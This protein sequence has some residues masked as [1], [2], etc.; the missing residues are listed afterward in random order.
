MEKTMKPPR[1][2]DCTDNIKYIDHFLQLVIK[3]TTQYLC[4]VLGYE[5][6]VGMSYSDILREWEPKNL[7]AR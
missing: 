3:A 1:E 2:M 4:E 7:G 6:L 5:Y